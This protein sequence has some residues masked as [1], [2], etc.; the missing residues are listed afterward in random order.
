ME[1]DDEA[2]SFLSLWIPDVDKV[3]LRALYLELEITHSR[4]LWS[5]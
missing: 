2:Y 3:R 4:I 1:Y 5:T